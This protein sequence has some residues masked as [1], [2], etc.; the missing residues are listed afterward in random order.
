MDWIKAHRVRIA[1]GIVVIIII[2][3]IYN[4]VVSDDRTQIL[5]PEQEEQAAQEA[6]AV[7]DTFDVVGDYL[8]P[9]MGNSKD[10][11]MTDD[12]REGKT[13][14]QEEKKEQKTTVKDDDDDIVESADI[15]SDT[16]PAPPAPKVVTEPAEAPKAPTVTP[17][18]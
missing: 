13:T 11:L 14:Q 8:F 5:T 4:C 1:I 16:K 10:E 9:T 17:I 6:S 2:F 7:K 15:S 18:E 12:E 3:T